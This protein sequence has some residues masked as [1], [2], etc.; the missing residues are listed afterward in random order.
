MQ[1]GKGRAK[2]GA[3]RNSSINWIF[4]RRLPFKNRSKSSINEKK[5]KKANYS[6][7]KFYKDLS[8]LIRPACQ[9]LTKTLDISRETALIATDLLKTPTILSDAIVRISA[10]DREDLKTILKI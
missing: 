10:V 5:Q 1:Y 9:T 3:L 7:L 4:L 2:N 6:N 8:L